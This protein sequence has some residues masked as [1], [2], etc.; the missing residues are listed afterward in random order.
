MKKEPL[1]ICEKCKEEKEIY[2]FRYARA[3]SY[4][5]KDMY[6]PNPFD[7]VRPI[8]WCAK[9]RWTKWSN[10]IKK[11]YLFSNYL[12]KL[13]YPKHIRELTYNILEPRIFKDCSNLVISY[14]E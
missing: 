3:H 13:Y 1:K 8:T 6:P 7:G 11:H 14:L 2:D 4:Y 9:C 10:T 12:D 5:P